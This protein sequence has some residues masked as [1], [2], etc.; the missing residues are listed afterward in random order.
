MK[1]DDELSDL[2][3]RRRRFAEGLPGWS[4]GP[5]RILTLLQCATRLRA[6]E[7][8]QGFSTDVPWESVLAQIITWHHEIPLR[9]GPCDERDAVDICVAALEAPRLDNLQYNLGVGGYEVRRRGDSLRIRQRWNSA[10]EA[11]DMFLE[12]A[13]T[14]SKLPKITSIEQRWIRNRPGTSRDLPPTQVLHAATQRA[15]TAVDAYRHALPE[16]NLPDSFKLDEG[17]TVGDAAAVLSALMGFALLCESAAYVLKRTET[18]LATIR[19]FRLLQMIAELLPDVRPAHIDTVIER[20]T[21]AAG[22]SSRVSPL[23]RLDDA[24]IVCPPLITPRSVDAILLRSAAY[25]PARYGP[26]GQRQGGRAARWKTWL[27]QVPGLLV[28]ERI[29]ARR[30]DQSAAGDLDVVAVDPQQRRGICFEIKWPIDAISY[31]EV[32][33]IEDWITSAAAQVDRLRADLTSGKAAV[34]MPRGWPAFFDIDWTWVVGTPQQL[35]LRPVPF[36]EIYATSFRY[37]AGHGIPR[38]LDDVIDTITSP[39]LPS[40]GTHYK[41]S[42]ID[43]MLGR[44]RVVQ[45][46]IGLIRDSW[47]PRPW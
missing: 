45:D 19:R 44:H 47:E 14:P 15:K 5:E 41:L 16:G 27:D 22:R 10:L 26:V 29:P 7:F 4:S 31:P 25:D 12:D 36:Q 8:A 13:A 39:D 9:A 32:A 35:G 46:A 37:L 33:K 3:G 18:M 6:M 28:A 17:L 38:T 34:A 24:I 30:Q 11:A 23:T 21:F 1:P 43:F 20:L 42:T 2:I 40:D